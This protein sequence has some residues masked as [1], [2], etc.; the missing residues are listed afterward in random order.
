MGMEDRGSSI[1]KTLRSLCLN[2]GWS[3][4]VLW[5]FDPRNH[6]ML[7]ME[8][9][10]YEEHLGSV[11]HNMLLQVHM[12]GEGKIGEA[13]LDG[14]HRWMF[15]DASNE[16]CRFM[17]H[18]KG[19]VASWDDSEFGIQISS[20]I[21]TVAVIPVESQ[22][23][24]Q[25]GST[26]EITETPEF[27][28]Q[29]R[30][31]FLNKDDFVGVAPAGSAS[32]SLNSD[33]TDLDGLFASM[34]SSQNSLF[35]N[36]E[37]IIDPNL[38]SLVKDSIYEDRPS[39]LLET[40]EEQFEQTQFPASSFDPCQMDDLSQ[41]LADSSRL[42]ISG[43]DAG[44]SDGISHTIEV[45]CIPSGLAGSEIFSAIHKQSTRSSLSDALN[46]CGE[47]AY[48]HAPSNNGQLAEF[49]TDF[50]CQ[51]LGECLEDIINPVGNKGDP[52]PIHTGMSI[53]ECISGMESGSTAAPLKGLF[54]ELGLEHLLSDGGCSSSITKSCIDDEWPTKKRRIETNQTINNQMQ[55]TGHCI[56]VKLMQPAA[57]S[58]GLKDSMRKSQAGLWMDDSYSMDAKS[59]MS[60]VN[61]QTR[62]PEE[63]VKAM[64]KRA[65]PGECTKPRPKDRQ[66]IADRIRELRDIIPN[67][68]KL[69][70]DVLLGRTVK[71]MIYMQSLAKHG[72]RLKQVDEPKLIGQENG[73]VKKGN[74]G[75]SD[76]G[77]ATWAYEV[78]GTNLFCPIIVEDLSHSGQMLIEMLCEEEGYFLEIADIVRGFG[79]TILKG[80]MEARDDKIWAHF[81]VEG[82]RHVNVTRMDVLVSLM[83]LLQ[84]TGS[85]I[86]ARAQLVNNNGA[87]GPL[88]SNYQQHLVPI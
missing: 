40:F 65:R 28:D 61:T 81:V 38:G 83:Q 8:D 79:L 35:G 37:L 27:L 3:Y 60:S 58:G 22:G 23:V 48:F 33:Y 80:V 11:V 29:A 71:H 24:V 45:D 49:G 1:K 52:M 19:Q 57:S 46:S 68:A 12:L 21:K 73:L 7:T 87:G 76:S 42:C 10:Y 51:N 67:G 6:M 13:S 25:F 86:E 9:A 30:K 62:R 85:R 72:D 50:G 44:V 63:P 17:D 5:R 43:L 78:G 26:K 82:N 64:K 88:W 75:G 47:G 54:S 55:L 74:S 31:F 20:G 4:G 34:I 41:W 84:G 15:L 77:G 53:S 56:G 66:M 39:N 2:N 16:Q 36:G 32:S 14:K 70:I 18:T 69:S 59:C